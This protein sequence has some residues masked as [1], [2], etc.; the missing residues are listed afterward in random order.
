MAVCVPSEGYTD[1]RIPHDLGSPYPAQHGSETPDQEQQELIG[2]PAEQSPWNNQQAEP[3]PYWQEGEYPQMAFGGNWVPMSPLAMPL[4]SSGSQSNGGGSS[5]PNR[6]KRRFCTSYPDVSN[7]RRGSTCAF[8][9]TREEIQAPLLTPEEENQDPKAM[10]DDFFMYKYKTHWCPIGVQH[11]WHTCVYAHNYQ[12]ARR[13]VS[14]GYGAK[15]CP[16]WSKKDTGAEYAQRCPLGLRCPYAH[17]AKEQLYHPQYFK[18][19]ICRDLRGK[20][21]P[22]Q[23]LCAFF[24]NRQER[25]HPG[26][27]GDDRDYSQ[28]LAEEALDDDWISDFLNP[29]FLPEYLRGGEDM[30]F[31]FAQDGNG[32]MPYGSPQ[33][34]NAPYGMQQNFVILLPSTMSPQQNGPCQMGMQMVGQ[35]P[36]NSSMQEPMPGSMNSPMQEPMNGQM[37]GSMQYVLL[38][39]E[40]APQA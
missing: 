6:S 5:Q 14:I 21:C 31:D 11:E 35:S 7:C 27:N 22:R 13:P 20:A 29:P 39:M 40:C 2:A 36:M 38:P 28:P 15:L 10:T 3:V 30:A 33:A 23:G 19:V 34:N 26:G 17:G 8:A 25:R 37:N 4:R 16:Y 9:H 1:F 12:D 24:H 18:T 32:V